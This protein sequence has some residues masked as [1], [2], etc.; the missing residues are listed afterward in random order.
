M[1]GRNANEKRRFHGTTMH[2]NCYFG[3]TPTQARRTCLLFGQA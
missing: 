3:I 1:P 2:E